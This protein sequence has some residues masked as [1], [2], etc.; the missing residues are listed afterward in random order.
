MNRTDTKQ[1]E[2]TN[3]LMLLCPV[4]QSDVAETLGVTG[5]MDGSLDSSVVMICEECKTV[6]LSPN[7]RDA[8][9]PVPVSSKVYAPCIRTVKEGVPANTTFLLADT[10]ERTLLSRDPAKDTFGLILI[11]LSLESSADPGALLA[12]AGKLIDSKGRV[13][14]LLGNTDSSS[15]ATFGGRHWFGYRFPHTRQ[16]FGAAGLSVIAKKAGLRVDESY[17]LASAQAW[18]TSLGNLLQDWGAHKSVVALLTGR[19]LIPWLIAS[20]F[21]RVALLRGRASVLVVQMKRD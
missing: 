6:Y 3:I 21:E 11:P 5:R 19:W 20:L 16:H 13:D 4:C 9:G 12:H 10:F 17:S 1:Q 18:L 2:H 15:F 14:V 8:D 7:P